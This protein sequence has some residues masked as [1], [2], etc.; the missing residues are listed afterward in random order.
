MIGAAKTT[1]K[2]KRKEVS[3]KHLVKKAIS[4]ISIDGSQFSNSKDWPYLW[5]KK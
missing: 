1:Q 3:M 2:I 5:K 4:V